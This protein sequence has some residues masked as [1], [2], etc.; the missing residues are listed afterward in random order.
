MPFRRLFFSSFNLFSALLFLS[1]FFFLLSIAELNQA[2][3]DV[4][5]NQERQAKA[6]QVYNS[7]KSEL[8]A[9]NKTLAD[10]K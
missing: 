4:A 3:K 7:R 1:S 9:A 8:D 5:R 2:N 10:A 6:V